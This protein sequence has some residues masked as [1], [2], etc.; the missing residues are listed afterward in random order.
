VVVARYGHGT[1]ERNRLKR[2][3]REIARRDLLPELK[4]R[5][6]NLDIIL[7]AKREAYGAM[8]AELRHGLVELLGRRWARASSS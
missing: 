6:L 1:V 8:H 2:R 7:R 5:G 4:R 3:L